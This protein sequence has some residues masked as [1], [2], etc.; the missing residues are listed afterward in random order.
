MSLDDGVTT[1]P[2]RRRPTGWIVLTAVLAVVAVGLGIWAFSAQADAD[3]TQKQLDA[4]QQQQA[5]G[6]DELPDAEATPA[7]ESAAT[8]EPEA[9]DADTQQRYDDVKDE[10]GITGE[11]VDEVD[12]KLD[13]AVASAEKAEQA[14][15]D[16]TNAVD[17]AGAE[18]EAF[19][20]QAE[21]AR[22]CL[23]G[24]LGALDAAF[25]SGGVQAA[26]TEL[27]TLSGQCRSAASP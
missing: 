19:K 26:V 23:S 2:E 18:V 11:N 22:A 8:P 25:S 6:A 1:V 17:R 5:V 20:A 12:A 21:V 27:E 3:D 10:L 24:T 4:Q 14:R 13:Q 9:V 16:A 7:Q 15:T